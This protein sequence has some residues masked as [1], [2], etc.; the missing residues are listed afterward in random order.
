MFAKTSSASITTGRHS[1]PQANCRAGA[2]LAARE[3]QQLI[4]KYAASFD[5]TAKA[6]FDLDTM[7]NKT[8]A[9][10]AVTMSNTLTEV[11]QLQTDIARRGRQQKP[12]TSVTEAT[13]QFTMILSAGALVDRSWCMAWLIGRGIS[14]P[15][16]AMTAAMQKLAGGDKSVGDS[17]ARPARRTDR[18]D[19]RRRRD[20]QT[21]HDR[22][23]PALRAEQEQA[24]AQR[25]SREA[26]PR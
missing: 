10:M 15:V 12:I 11:R 20:L 2:A 17:G 7:V 13:S 1:D 21:Q 19:G 23:R 8:M 6:A 24:K 16:I 9:D 5:E 25:R 14:G 26:A 4:K 3:S 18:P 22:S